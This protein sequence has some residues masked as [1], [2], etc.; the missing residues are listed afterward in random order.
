MHVR[1]TAKISS[2]DVGDSVS[3]NFDLL[4][5]FHL[6]LVSMSRRPAKL[7]FLPR[8][9]PLTSAFVSL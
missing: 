9:L 3:L 5:R 8:C 2:M 6:F 7:Y 1:S 4:E